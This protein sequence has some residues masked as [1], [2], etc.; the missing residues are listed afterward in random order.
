[1]QW[2]KYQLCN[3]AISVAIDYGRLSW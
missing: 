2:K 1:M 3:T